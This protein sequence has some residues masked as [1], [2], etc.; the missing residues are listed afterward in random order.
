[1]GCRKNLEDL[2][3]EV[4]TE[5]LVCLPDSDL[6]TCVLHIN[7]LWKQAAQCKRVWSHRKYQVSDEAKEAEIVEVAQIIPQ[8]TTLQFTDI[9]DGFEA[10]YSDETLHISCS[11]IARKELINCLLTKCLNI[12]KLYLPSFLLQREDFADMVGS[13]QNLRSLFPESTIGYIDSSL[14]LKPL[15]DGAPQLEEV[16]F[17]NQ[18][19]DIKDITYFMDKKGPQLRSLTINWC[20]NDEISALPLLKNCQHSLRKLEI[21]VNG[22]GT[23]ETAAILSTLKD[24]SA[25]TDLH[26]QGVANIDAVEITCAL[27][28]SSFTQ[29]R[30]F[31]ITCAFYIQ[32]DV[33]L[34]LCTCCPLLQEIKLRD[35]RYITARGLELI[36]NCTDLLILDLSGCVRIQ[37]LGTLEQCT[38]LNALFLT[39]CWRLQ[40]SA[41]TGILQLSELRTLRIDSCCTLGFPFSN[42]KTYLPHLEFLG[43]NACYGSTLEELEELRNSAPELFISLGED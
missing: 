24:L 37:D 23:F 25:L 21:Y 9:P 27:L 8:L 20:T 39:D 22:Q 28:T 38:K 43:I 26:F 12:T 33:L 40:P 30:S 15:A 31:S 14:V 34:A 13:M 19:Y 42:L 16:D 32:D 11:L 4:I 7:P 5:I 36:E 17:S 3:L 10:T 18:Y 35:S 1:M 6:I 41:L 2:P 29:L